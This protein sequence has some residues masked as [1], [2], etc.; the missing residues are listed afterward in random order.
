MN[1]H[2]YSVLSSQGRLFSTTRFF[3]SVFQSACFAGN[4][5]G[6]HVVRQPGGGCAL[7]LVPSVRD[8][9]WVPLGD[10]WQVNLILPD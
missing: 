8:E 10:G 7:S 9:W 6:F 2:K 5:W 1:V 4:M 3:F